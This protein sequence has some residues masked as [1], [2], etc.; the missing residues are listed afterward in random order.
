MKRAM[1]SA[2]VFFLIIAALTVSMTG[3]GCDKGKNS[4][5]ISIVTTVF[6]AYDWARE[7]IGDEK[8]RFDIS[9]I[10]DNGTDL[11][12]YQPTAEDILAISECDLLIYVGGASD[13]WVAEAAERSGN[14]EMRV[15]SLLDAAGEAVLDEE[16]LNGPG[17]DHS[18]GDE[19]HDESDEHVWLSLR[20]AQILTEELEE[21]IASADPSRGATYEKNAVEYIG[22][23]HELDQKYAAKFEK[24]SE[25][26]LIFADRFPFRYLLND[27]GIDYRAAFDGCSAETEADFETLVYLID[28]A[29]LYDVPMI[30]TMEGS[31][32]KIAR[33]VAA[34]TEKDDQKIAAVNSMQYVTSGDIEDGASYIKIMENNL[35]ILSEALGAREK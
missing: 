11:H 13:E 19:A 21:E 10:A 5:K 18:H 3:R 26:V 30:L 20:A 12:S 27:Y 8:D 9:L 22:R 31:D 4:E 16:H 32:G 28:Q 6:P 29:D 7:I 34:G 25:N 24:A 14:K 1:I 35:E 33:T 15:I 2:L 23:L 17:G